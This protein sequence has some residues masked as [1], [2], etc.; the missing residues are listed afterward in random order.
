MPYDATKFVGQPEPGK[1]AWQVCHIKNLGRKLLKGPHG[2]F[3]KR[4]VLVVFW[5]MKRYGD[6]ATLCGVMDFSMKPDT[7]FRMLLEAMK[8]TGLPTGLPT[9]ASIIKDEKAFLDGLDKSVQEERP[10]VKIEATF[11][12]GHIKLATA[13]PAHPWRDCGPQPLSALAAAIYERYTSAYRRSSG[14]NQDVHAEE[15]VQT[16]GAVHGERVG[17]AVQ[18]SEDG[19]HGGQRLGEMEGVDIVSEDIAE[20]S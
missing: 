11:G 9:G 3:V 8:V 16:A 17:E 19:G 4:M 12:H 18:C 7:S 6:L 2:E 20:R 15:K 14:E 5:R 1:P 10:A 13:S